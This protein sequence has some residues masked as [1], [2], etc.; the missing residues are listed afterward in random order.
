[1]GDD[2]AVL[3]LFFFAAKD[4]PTGAHDFERARGR[5]LR[6]ETQPYGYDWGDWEFV[7]SLNYRSLQMGVGDDTGIWRIE[8]YVEGSSDGSPPSL[9]LGPDERVWV[10]N[11]CSLCHPV[12]VQGKAPD[13]EPCLE[14]LRAVAENLGLD[15]QHV[16]GSADKPAFIEAVRAKVAL[17]RPVSR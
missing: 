15:F 11:Y 2:Q 7:P 13:G 4:A 9:E 1:M 10:V 8:P 17:R 14:H 12:F 3:D 16:R 6:T 5:A